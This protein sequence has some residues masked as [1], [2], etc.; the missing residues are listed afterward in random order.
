MSLEQAPHKKRAAEISA[1]FRKGVSKSLAD[2]AWPKNAARDARVEA[3]AQADLRSEKLTRLSPKETVTLE[4]DWQTRKNNYGITISRF[5]K[6][7]TL[8]AVEGESYCAAIP[9]DVWQNSDGAGGY[10]TKLNAEHALHSF[11]VPCSH[12]AAN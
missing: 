2:S 4:A 12:G 7:M 8:M 11:I 3:A 9:G 6:T 5:K 10:D 1:E